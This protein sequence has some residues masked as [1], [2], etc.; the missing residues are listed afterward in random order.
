[1]SRSTCGPSASS[2][3]DMSTMQ[4]GGWGGWGGLWLMSTMQP[5]EEALCQNVNT[6]SDEEM[7]EY[8]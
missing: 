8:R 5:I 4:V 7:E 3:R 6:A 2:S 1:M